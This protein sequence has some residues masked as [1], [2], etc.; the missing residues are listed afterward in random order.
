MKKVILTLI[1]IISL[2][3]CA[4]IVHGD[5]EDINII[6]EPS[7]A[8]FDV[9]ELNKYNQTKILSG[10]T[11]TIIDLESAFDV[12]E[13]AKYK[14]IIK[15]N[16]FKTAEILINSDVSN[17]FL[18]GNLLNGVVGW[19]I[20]AVTGAMYHLEPDKIHISLIPNA[21]NNKP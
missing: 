19:G 18:I 21:S 11:P 20:D 4:T 15:K 5:S 2:S 9:I 1:A 7:G 13:G 8:S 14:I 16:G 3:S 12:L 6:T 17:W 10:V